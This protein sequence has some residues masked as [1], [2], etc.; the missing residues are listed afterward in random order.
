M[1]RWRV[2]RIKTLRQAVVDELIDMAEDISWIPL[3]KVDAVK[4]NDSDYFNLIYALVMRIKGSLL[5]QS[6]ERQ[7]GKYTK[8]MGFR[9]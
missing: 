4:M 5:E 9:D 3:E 8:M 1:R 7:I 6:A 2:Y